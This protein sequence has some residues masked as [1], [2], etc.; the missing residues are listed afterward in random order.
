LLQAKT[1]GAKRTSGSQSGCRPRWIMPR[2]TLPPAR[3]R[4]TILGQFHPVPLHFDW[5]LEPRPV[6]ALQ[7]ARI[8]SLL[9]T[10]THRKIPTM[11]HVRSAASARPPSQLGTRHAGSCATIHLRRANVSQIHA[12]TVR[13]AP[14]YRSGTFRKS[15]R[16]FLPSE[17]TTLTRAAVA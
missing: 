4:Q 17:K 2:Q 1:L 10:Q 15:I 11:D 5:L 13:P 7:A 14:S 3:A 16:A 9:M 12:R 8:H 6:I